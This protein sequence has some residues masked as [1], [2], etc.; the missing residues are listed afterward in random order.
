M[1][2]IT[3]ELT[4]LR[5]RIFVDKINNRELKYLCTSKGMDEYPGTMMSCVARF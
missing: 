5:E 1:K 3:I 4:T 2:I